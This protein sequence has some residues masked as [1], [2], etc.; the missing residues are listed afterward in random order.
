MP[1]LATKANNL[2]GNRAI[3]RIV[4]RAAADYDIPL[5]NFWTAA[6]P[7][8]KQGL[9]EYLFPLSKEFPLLTMPNQ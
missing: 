9:M 8:T 1:I 4:A 2:N 3:N 7:L 6:L 5:W